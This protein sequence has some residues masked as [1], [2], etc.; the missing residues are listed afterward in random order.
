MDLAEEEYR[1]FSSGLTPGK[2]N[3]LGVRLPKLRNLAKTIAKGD[4]RAY[5]A[6]AGTETFEEVML[7]GMVIGYIKADIEEI[8]KLMSKFIPLIDN[9]AVCDSFCNGL[10]ITKKHLELVWDFLKP[11]LESDKE[12]EIRFGVVMLLNYY[13]DSNYAPMAFAYFDNIKHS[14]YYVKMAVAWAISI[15]FI[16]LPELTLRYLK[17]NALD[18]F[19]YHKALQKIRESL[20]V[21]P[22]TKEMIRTMKRTK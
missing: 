1:Q 13:I 5:L 20:R 10:K 6:E 3:I 9:W 19:T 4:W 2:D 16:N 22:E 17:E 15:Y 21:D 11:Y 12:Y 7:Q 8:L 18:D 14:G